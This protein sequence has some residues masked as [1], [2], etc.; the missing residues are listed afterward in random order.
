MKL[1]ERDAGL[2][3]EGDGQIPGPIT[4]SADPIADFIDVNGKAWD[5]KSFSTDW[6]NGY[7]YNTAMCEIL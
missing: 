3:C 1:L 2:G 4:R 5:V 7:D 6:K